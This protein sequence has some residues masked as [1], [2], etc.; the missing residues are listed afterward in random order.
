M[1]RITV[2]D[3]LDHVDNRFDLVLLATKRAR[4]LVNGVDP[5]LPWENDKPTVMALREIAEGLVD[6]QTVAPRR[7]EIEMIVEEGAEDMVV[8]EPTFG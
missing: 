7:E 5:L 8:E 2:Q 1:A 3:C 4:Q 6:D